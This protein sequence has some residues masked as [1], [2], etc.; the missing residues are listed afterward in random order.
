MAAE[1]FRLSRVWTVG[2]L[3]IVAAGPLLSVLVFFTDNS[4]SFFRSRPVFSVL[5]TMAPLLVIPIARMVFVLNQTPLL[6][7]IDSSGLSGHTLVGRFWA[8][9]RAFSVRW[10]DLSRVTARG[11]MSSAL[12]IEDTAG[13]EYTLWMAMVAGVKSDDSATIRDAIVAASPPH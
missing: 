13:E 7:R 9:S 12:V 11:G 10:S 6:L 8:Q 5:A 1:E 3:G 4:D 2:V